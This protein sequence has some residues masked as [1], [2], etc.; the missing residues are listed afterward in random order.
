MSDNYTKRGPWDVDLVLHTYVF[1]D[2][3]ILMPFSSFGVNTTGIWNNVLSKRGPINTQWGLPALLATAHDPPILRWKWT[4]YRSL[5][6]AKVS[7][8]QFYWKIRSYSFRKYERYSMYDRE[9]FEFKISS[10]ISII[11]S[12]KDIEHR[13]RFHSM[14]LKTAVATSSPRMI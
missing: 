8:F 9:I 3:Y 13:C 7:L 5:I 11:I 2:N 6:T 12:W 1:L 4:T 14:R 10:N